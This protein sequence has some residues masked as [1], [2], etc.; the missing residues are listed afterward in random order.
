MTQNLFLFPEHVRKIAFAGDWHMN[1]S[2]AV[3]AIHYAA[4][5]N[6]DVIVQVGDFGFGFTYY[7]EYIEKLTEILEMKNLSL[8]FIDGNHENFDVLRSYNINEH[9][10]REVSSRIAHLPR[11][12]R[13]NWG[14]ASFLALG[15]AFSIDRSHRV[16]NSSWWVEEVISEIDSE[17]AIEGGHADFMITHDIPSGVD[18]KLTSNLSRSV[19]REYEKHRNIL[20]KVVDFVKPDELIGGHYHKRL[21]DVLILDNGHEVNVNVL[22]CD[23]FINL[24]DNN[25]NISA[26]ANNVMFYELF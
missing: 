21:N 11:G 25:S 6:A 8:L 24:H 23:T 9:S 20:R 26:F 14:E 4:D 17:N 5:N 1:T 15:G 16:K 7:N 22:D 13:W 19:T 18:L 10:Y 2:F 12:F 3:E